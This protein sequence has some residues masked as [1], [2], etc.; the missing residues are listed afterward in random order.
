MRGIYRSNQPYKMKSINHALAEMRYLARWATKNGYTHDLS[1]WND[2]TCKT[3]LDTIRDT[4]AI[5]AKRSAEDLFRH[6]VNFGALMEGGGLRTTVAPF[7]SA[8]STVRSKLRSFRQPLS[9]L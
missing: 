4:R 9:G 3:Y 6:L 8:Q 1:Q 7:K 5:S 2:D